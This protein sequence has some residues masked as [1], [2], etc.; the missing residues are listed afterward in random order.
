MSF[1]RDT[2]RDVIELKA[3]GVDNEILALKISTIVLILKI[4]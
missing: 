1:L 3:I 4:M 2:Y